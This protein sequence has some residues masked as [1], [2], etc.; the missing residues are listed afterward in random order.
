[1]DKIDHDWFNDYGRISCPN[2]THIEY[3][4]IIDNFENASTRTLISL[5]EAR[6]LL[7]NID[8]SHIKT[9]YDFWNERRSSTRVHFLNLISLSGFQQ[10]KKIDFN[11][12]N[13]LKIKI[14]FF[15]NLVIFWSHVLVFFFIKLIRTND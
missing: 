6:T 15:S 2:L 9:V 11:I 10:R 8:D 12:F 3:E 14:Y 1:M 7:P 4:T 5:D 13:F